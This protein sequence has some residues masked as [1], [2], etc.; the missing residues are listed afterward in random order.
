MEYY[1]PRVHLSTSNVISSPSK[2]PNTMA[3]DEVCPTLLI[4]ASKYSINPSKPRVPL[5]PL[6]L[7]E[8]CRNTGIL[9]PTPNLYTG[10]QAT[11]CCLGLDAFLRDIE[12]SSS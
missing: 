4:Q 2:T 3:L 11:L 8:H 1:A 9:E 6:P 12:L 7:Y 10:V 5:N